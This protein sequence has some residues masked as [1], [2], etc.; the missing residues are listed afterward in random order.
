MRI[1]H[2]ERH[3]HVADASLRGDV[4]GVECVVAR[5]RVRH[6]DR[7]A[8]DLD[9]FHLAH[10]TGGKRILLRR[11]DVVDL[12]FAQ[13]ERAKRDVGGLHLLRLEL[14]HAGI[15]MPLLL[16][17][18]RIDR[19][20]HPVLLVGVGGHLLDAAAKLLL[21]RGVR[22]LDPLIHL[23][24]ALQANR[25]RGNAERVVREDILGVGLAAHV[26]QLALHLLIDRGVRLHRDACPLAFIDSLG[27][28]DR[29]SL[30]PEQ[31]REPRYEKREPDYHALDGT[32]KT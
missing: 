20:R 25:R 30:V 21:L 18:A 4:A 6:V 7:A 8:L 12:A 14:H 24:I 23:H 3:A 28:L 16:E 32:S 19:G 22:L 29:V 9:A 27:R 26:D 10:E 13:A 17:T 1:D 15:V 31:D 5:L 11:T 2:A